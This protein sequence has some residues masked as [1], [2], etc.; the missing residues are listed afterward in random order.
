MIPLQQTSHNVYVLS[1]MYKIKYTFL[2]EVEDKG[3]AALDCIILP[4]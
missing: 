2:T 1:E 4:I 3:G